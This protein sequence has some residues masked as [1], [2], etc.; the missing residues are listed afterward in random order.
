MLFMVYQPFGHKML[1]V[2]TKI[3][4]DNFELNYWG[5][6]W[7]LW[8]A[9]SNIFFGLIHVMAVKWGH[10]DV[11]LFLLKLDIVVYAMFVLLVIWGISAK[12]MGTGVYSVF[13]VFGFWLFWSIYS[14]YQYNTL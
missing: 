10:L 1:V 5:K 6:L 2:W 13:V 9:G 7:L 12:R 4:K 8:A 3:F 14:L 11:K